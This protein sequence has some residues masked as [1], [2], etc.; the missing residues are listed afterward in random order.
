MVPVHSTCFTT[1]LIFI[2]NS[3]HPNSYKQTPAHH[4]I[5]GIDAVAHM[6]QAMTHSVPLLTN[7]SSIIVKSASTNRQM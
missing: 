5:C 3:S 2:F 7:L 1:N 6:H 4:Y